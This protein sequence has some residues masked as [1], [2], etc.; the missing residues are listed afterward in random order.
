MTTISTP[1][2]RGRREGVGGERW[3]EK[4]RGRVG[5]ESWRGGEEKGEWG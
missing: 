1:G 2:G 4:G 5:E 3:R